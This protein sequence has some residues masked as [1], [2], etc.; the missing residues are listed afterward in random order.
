MNKEVSMEVSSEDAWVKN[1]FFNE[2]EEVSKPYEEGN[3][4]AE[5]PTGYKFKGNKTP[6]LKSVEN[7]MLLMKSGHKKESA[8]ISFRILNSKQIPNGIEKEVEVTKDKDIGNA[9][10]KFYG[11][12]KKGCTVI[13]SKTKKE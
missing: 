9:L 6:F 4:P 3:W 2:E 13:I 1:E 11:P 5:N 8:K 12:S 7:L 10:I